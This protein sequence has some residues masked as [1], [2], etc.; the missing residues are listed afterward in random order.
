M[1]GESTQALSSEQAVQ[2][3]GMQAP[4]LE[5]LVFGEAC[6]D[7]RSD[8]GVNKGLDASEDRKTRS[9]CHS[10]VVPESSEQACTV[11]KVRC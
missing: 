6:E 3:G 2:A 10:A 11:T 5:A 8:E 9:D 1:H 4:F 7:S